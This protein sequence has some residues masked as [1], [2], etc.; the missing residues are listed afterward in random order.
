MLVLVELVVTPLSLVAQG[1]VDNDNN[2]ASKNSSEQNQGNVKLIRGTVVDSQGKPV[3]GAMLWYEYA[4]DMYSSTRLGVDARSDAEGRFTLEIPI[5]PP[6]THI[7]MPS[8]VWAYSPK[9]CLGSAAPASRPAE[10]DGDGVRIELALATDTSLLVLQPNGRP[11]AG[12]LV[13]PINY[14]SV[15]GYDLVPAGAMPLVGGR[16]DAE[17]RVRLPAMARD[18][19]FLPQLTTETY[20]VQNSAIHGPCW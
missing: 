6:G 11:A 19:L 7:E 10:Q 2:P 16:T 12:V 9:H 1:E 18:R 4:I 8:L 3:A 15:W 17:G 14:R 20:G 13:E 5:A